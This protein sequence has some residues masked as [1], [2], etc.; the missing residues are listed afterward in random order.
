M[1]DRPL[2]TTIG[3]TKSSAERFFG[4]LLDAI[5][6][7]VVDVRLH[8]TSQLAGFAKS[9]DLSYFLKRIGNISYRHMPMLAPE[10]GML[11]DYK[12]GGGSWLAYEAEFKSLMARRKIEE[13]INP[14][15]LD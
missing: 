10:D 8:N 3:F 11:S 6:R 9:E 15:L 7:L 13:K 4:R 1:A 2:V 12:K 14:D 5:V